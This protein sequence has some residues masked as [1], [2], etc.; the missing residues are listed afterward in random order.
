MAIIFIPAGITILLGNNNQLDM[1]A[2]VTQKEQEENEMQQ[3]LNEQ[4]TG[5]VAKT[6]SINYEKE[7]LKAQA[8]IAYSQIILA[9]QDTKDHE[10]ISYM[11]IEEM[12]QLW[13]SNFKRNY[14][15][16]KKAVEETDNMMLT[17]DSDPVQLV[18]HLQNTG[19]TQSSLDIWDID[20][21]YLKNVE[22][23]EDQKAPNL[24]NQK[25]YSTQEVI[26]KINQYYNNTVLESYCLETQIQIIERTK[27][28]YVKSIQ[29]GNQLMRGDDFRKVL[30]LKSSCFTFQ[31]SGNEMM[32]VTKGV[33]HGVGL[34]QYGAN[35]MAKKGKTYNEILQHYFPGTIITNKY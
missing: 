1:N 10:S 15:K 9:Q 22:S 13:G 14:S 35:E 3:M 11:S 26:Q 12:K 28:G 8:V 24:V 18:Y 19:Q 25:K 2:P 30:N 23:L 29:V 32:V 20:V 6:M 5:I 27:G 7:A 33:G 34:S 31:Y 16:I 17:Y 21:P 4:I